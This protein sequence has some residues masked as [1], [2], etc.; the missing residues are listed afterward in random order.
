MKK[1]LY[2]MHVPWGWIK[3]RPHFL[4]E[5]LTRHFDVHVFHRK[6]FGRNTLV[7]N[8]VPSGLTVSVI[9]MLRL[10]SLSG[11]MDHLN[12]RRIARY[13]G[14]HIADYDIVWVAHPD[15]FELVSPVVP[16]SAVV[17]YDCMDDHGAFPEVSCNAG[18]ARRLWVREQRL[19]DRSD[20]VFVS[21]ESLGETLRERY[22]LARQPLVVNNGLSLEDAADAPSLPA[23]VAGPMAEASFRLVYIGTIAPWLDFPLILETVERFPQVTVF[24]C[25]PSDE[26]IPAH[27]RIV[28]LGPIQHRYV[29][30]VMAA[31]DALFMPFQLCE[32]VR[33]VDPVKLYE[34]V[35]SCKPAL[36]LRYPETLKFG[37]YI[38]L[39]QT[40][41]EFFELLA[42]LVS[43][44]RGAKK[45]CD[46][47]R[48]FS[49][50]NTW[51]MR[52][53]Y[54]ASVVTE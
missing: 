28:H 46:V 11:V 22:G 41:E 21:S 45:S 50:A 53:A 23:E 6:T 24:L 12:N 44:V 42:G 27:E 20:I 38:D 26:P 35:H 30:G 16:P 7:Q 3:Q 47:C 52:A 25:G 9:P 43:G 33:G 39:Y 17:V 31:A 5:E 34:Y 37:E 29:G 15:M 36:A 48:A 19:L 2:L 13:F 51:E 49:A 40:Q 54:I 10:T 32:L 18:L 1:L 8:I 14:A 4:A